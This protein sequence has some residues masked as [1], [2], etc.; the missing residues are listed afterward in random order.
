MKLYAISGVEKM[1]VAQILTDLGYKDTVLFSNPDYESAFIG[2]SDDDR[3][4][5]DYDLMVEYIMT[6]QDIPEDQAV[7]FID[8]NTI[9]ALPYT[10]N[11]P[12]VLYPINVE[13]IV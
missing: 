6:T 10:K 1:S 5:Y 2:L 13:E 12:V 4:V 11:A 8:Y 7:E 3:A 9:R